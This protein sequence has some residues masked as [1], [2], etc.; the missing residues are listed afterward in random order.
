MTGRQ[1]DLIIRAGR[2]LHP[3]DLE[4]AVE[5]LAGVRRGCVVAG[6]LRDGLDS[7]DEVVV[8]AETKLPASD[9]QALDELSG[10]VRAAVLDALG[11]VPERIVLLEPRSLPKTSSGKLQR[12]LALR[13]LAD[14]ELKPLHGG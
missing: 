7:T 2:N 5:P 4:A 12:R 1:S 11:V 6:G 3:Q 10:R 14:G 8:L 9:A 13:L